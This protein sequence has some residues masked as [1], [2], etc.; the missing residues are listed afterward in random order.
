MMKVKQIAMTV[1]LLVGPLLSLPAAAQE[2]VYG[3]KLNLFWSALDTADFHR[4][5]GSITL[6]FVFAETLTSLAK[7]GT[8]QGLLAE[9]WEISPDGRTYTFHLRQGVKFHNGRTMTSDDVRQNLERIRSEIKG[10][11]LTTAL[12][13]VESFDTPDENT[14]VAQLKVPFA[15]FLN[16]LAEAF[17]LAPESPGWDTNITQPI[18]TGPFTFDS[19]T[20]QV[21]ITGAKFADYWMPGKPYVDAINF[22]VREVADVTVPLRAGDYDAA[23]LLK[24]AATKAPKLREE[25]FAIAATGATEWAFLSFNNRSPRPPF[26]NLKVRE[27]IAYALD[28]PTMMK[29]MYGEGGVAGNQMVGEGDFF[30]DQATTADDPTLT[31]NLE[32]AKALLS[33]AGINPAD[34]RPVLVAPNA[35][36]TMALPAAQT[37][38]QLGFNPDVKLLDDLGYQRELSNY[39]WDIF[40]GGSG[41]RNDIYLRYVR[42][43]SDGPNPGLWGGIQDPE[44]DALIRAATEKVDQSELRDTYLK[45]WHRIAASQYTIGFGQSPIIFGISPKV[46]DLSI[47]FNLSPHRVD[48]GVA[49]AWIEK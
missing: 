30:Y 36:S 23:L 47:G 2:P 37:L 14:F 27:A 10:G 46:H 1:A 43:M 21:A 17:V 13:Q 16:L 8:P 45:A 11:W 38:R 31:Q 28:R 34:H 19:W 42:F 35:G 15:P 29:L 6:P 4:H 41:P 18:G 48:G 32:K 40:V 33:E 7:D 22:D 24:S 39:E 12:E 5:T 49:F 9:S 20:P 25:G 44:L 3:G 26:D